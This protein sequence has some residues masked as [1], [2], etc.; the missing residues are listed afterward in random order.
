MSGKIESWNPSPVLARKK[1]FS[2]AN[3]RETVNLHVKSCIVNPFLFANGYLQKKGGNPS[4]CFYCQKVKYEK[5]VSCVDHLSSVNLVTNVPTVGTIRDPPERWQAL[6]TKIQTILSGVPSPA[7]QVPHRSTHSNRKASLPRSAPYE[8][9]TVAL[10]EQLEGTRVNR[11]GD[12]SPQVAPPMLRMVA[13]GKQCAS[14]STITPT[15][16]CSTD[17]YRR[18]KR[19][20]VHS[21][22]RRGT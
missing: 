10:E 1:G 18:I 12:T 6:T 22:K 15:K 19:R 20:V 11:K 8:A 13:G 4:Y 5:N 17:L 7:V 14:R 3:K 2:V 16:T 9:H 21:H